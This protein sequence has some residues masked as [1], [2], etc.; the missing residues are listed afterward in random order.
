MEYQNDSE[1]DESETQIVIWRTLINLVKA[2]PAL[3]EEKHK[4]YNKKSDKLLMWNRIGISLEPPMTGTDAQEEFY[5][6]RQ[7]FGKE[8]RKV[9]QSQPKSGASGNDVPYKSNWI[10]YNNLMFLVDHIQP[11]Q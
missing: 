2:N 4:G 1:H 11:R 6:L 8:R 10:L 9:L 3:Y 5:R 7:K